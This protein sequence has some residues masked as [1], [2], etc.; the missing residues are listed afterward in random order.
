MITFAKDRHIK[1]IVCVWNEAFG[2]REE[3]V[4]RYLDTLLKYVLVYEE[5]GRVCGMLTLLPVRM[6]EKTGRYVYAVAT[7]KECRGKGISTMLLDFAKKFIKEKG[8]DFLILVPQEGSLV[9]FYAQRG[10]ETVCNVIHKEISVSNIQKQDFLAEK[11]SPEEYWNLR[12]KV[13]V[14]KKIVEWEADMLSFAK[15]M[16]GGEF[17]RINRN[18]KM[19]GAAF[20]FLHNKVLYIKEIC[21]NEDSVVA[22]LVAEFEP[23]TV[24]YALFGESGKPYAMMYP[25]LQKSVYFAI[26]L[27]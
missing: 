3:E 15:E 25:K 10:F 9:E 11:I 18:G 5:S 20:C 17:Y 2:D 6:G 27:D 7:L 21:G 22:A 23:K 4:L 26:A 16:Y 1:D 24:D 13:L 19:L 14:H 8:E 12:K